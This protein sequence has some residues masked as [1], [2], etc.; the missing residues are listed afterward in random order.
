MKFFAATMLLLGLGL[1]G[2]ACNAR[3]AP[4]S[5]FVPRNSAEPHATLGHKHSAKRGGHHGTGRGTSAKGGHHAN[6]Q[7]AGHDMHNA[8][9]TD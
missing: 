5:S 1:F 4:T 6:S 9:R 2:T 8:P 7:T 3:G